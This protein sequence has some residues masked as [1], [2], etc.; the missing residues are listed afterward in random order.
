M[1]LFNF[2][3]TVMLTLKDLYLGCH[4]LTLDSKP[5]LCELISFTDE[6]NIEIQYEGQKEMIT[7]WDIKG[8][9]PS[10]RFFDRRCDKEESL[11]NDRIWDFTDRIHPFKISR[12]NGSL[13]YS[14]Q[15]IEDKK[16][17]SLPF[18]YLHELQWGH[19]SF[20]SEIPDFH[21]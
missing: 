15:D 18:N 9:E 16:D 17:A 11:G 14:N 2:K 21:L 4:Y 5:V 8:V 1:V 7:I 19:K 3:N 6:S 13:F 12:I 20:Y 10:D